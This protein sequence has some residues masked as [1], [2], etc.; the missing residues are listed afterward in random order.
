MEPILIL[1]VMFGALI[2]TIVYLAQGLARRLRE[3]SRDT[4]SPGRQASAPGDGQTD[5][6]PG[7]SPGASAGRGTEQAPDSLA[8]DRPTSTAL[9]SPQIP[10]EEVPA[11]AGRR[12]TDDRVAAV[13][14]RIAWVDGPTANT[15]LLF[16]EVADRHG[17]KQGDRRFYIQI[18]YAYGD[19]EVD[20]KMQDAD[21]DRFLEKHIRATGRV[22]YD[23]NETHMVFEFPGDRGSIEVMDQ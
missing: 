11:W 16:F 4:S 14:G 19:S 2:I 10:W 6:S 22:I 23:S 21:A 13:T 12:P 20:K 9:T 1:I 15:T 17:S 7:P 3:R 5:G 18:L 8:G